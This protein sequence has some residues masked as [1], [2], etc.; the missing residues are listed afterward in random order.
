MKEDLKKRIANK[1]KAKKK[2]AK[3][4]LEFEFVGINF[5]DNEEEKEASDSPTKGSESYTDHTF[6]DKQ[7]DEAAVN[8]IEKQYMNY[9]HNLQDFLDD[10]NV[11][12]EDESTT[13]VSQT[14][15]FIHLPSTEDRD[16]VYNNDVDESVDKY[17]ED[18]V[19]NIKSQ[20]PT[21]TNGEE[22]IFKWD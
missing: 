12:D 9:A 3:G 18:T 20:K 13:P 4:A 8:F 14:P 7:D 1:G 11:S 5:E 21:G 17:S 2:A 6:A 10:E 15:K 16:N 22:G 19:K